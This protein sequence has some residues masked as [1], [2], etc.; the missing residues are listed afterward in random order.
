VSIVLEM[1]P[2]GLS[3][4][5][6]MWRATGISLGQLASCA[7]WVEAQERKAVRRKSLALAPWIRDVADCRVL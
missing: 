6:N 4:R 2:T 3:V 7:Y 5:G 1:T